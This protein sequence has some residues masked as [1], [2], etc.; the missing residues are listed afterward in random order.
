MELIFPNDADWTSYH[1]GELGAWLRDLPTAVPEGHVFLDSHGKAGNHTL[2]CPYLDLPPI[3]L[4]PQD[5]KIAND[6]RRRLW[7]IRQGNA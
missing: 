6:V 1:D 4:V 2:M 7:D 5:V 3:A